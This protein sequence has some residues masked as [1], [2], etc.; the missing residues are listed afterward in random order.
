MNAA[1]FG[2]NIE[3]DAVMQ[4]EPPLIATPAAVKPVQGPIAKYNRRV[5]IV[6]EDNDQI[7]PTGQ[8][9][10]HDGNGFMLRA[11]VP[12]I[13]PIEIVDILNNAVYSAPEVDQNT[14]QV[15]GYK[16]RL[17]FPYRITDPHPTLRSTPA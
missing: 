4:L 16:P 2:S 11:G 13:V 12:V 5:E 15:V 10:G 7:P 9:F 8:F 3:D 1:V 14:R 17:R 6:L